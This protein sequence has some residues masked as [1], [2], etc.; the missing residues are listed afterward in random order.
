[1]PNSKPFKVIVLTPNLKLQGGVSSLY[2]VLNL[3]KK[4][5]IEY[6]N[7]QGNKR[8]GI[9]LKPINLFW[10]YFSFILKVRR[11]NIVH[12]NPSM[13]NKSYYRDGIFLL[14]ARLFRKKV[15]VYWHGWN[16]SFQ[17]TL[18]RNGSYSSFHSKTYK[19]ANLHIVLG[20]SFKN[21]L[22]KMGILEKNIKIESNAADDS[23]LK[24]EKFPEKNFDRIELLFISRIEE[25]KGIYIVL[26]AMQILMH[27]GKYHLTIAGNGSELDNVKTY[28][29]DHRIS[30]ISISGHVEG[31]EKHKILSKSHIM[32]LPSFSEGMPISIIE[33]MLYGLVIVSRPIGG[34]PDWVKVP[35]NGYLIES[36]YENEYAEKILQ[37]SKD[38]TLMK[39][40]QENNR[41]IAG[42][43]FTP[44]ALSERLFK[45][46][47]SVLKS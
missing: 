29:N 7:V 3:T 24:K 39:D 17:K 9:L 12:I 16:Y 13:N 46:Y 28:I 21:E 40:I 33:A 6:F 15:I 8:G 4:K 36:L 37:I 47:N 25:Q 44:N 38:L 18:I 30:N 42:E 1:M 5:N 10:I 19:K 14:I 45:Y 35:N 20:S 27:F 23:F 43:N 22:L 41:K 11:F 34:I 26:K 2:N 32:I 31:I